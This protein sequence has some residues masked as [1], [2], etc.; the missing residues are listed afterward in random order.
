M[1]YGWKIVAVTCVTHFISVGFIFYSYGVFF[2]AL[3]EEFGGSRLSVSFGLALMNVATGIFAPFLGYLLDHR[4]IRNIMCIGTICMATGFLLASQI[5]ELWQFYFVLATFLGLGAAA[6]GGLPSSTLVAKW[7]VTQRGKALGISTMGISSSGLIMAPLATVLIAHIGWRQTFMAYSFASI[8]IVLPLVWFF[9]VSRPE[10]LGLHPDG[11][12]HDPDAEGA[13]EPMV[14]LAPGDQ[15]IDHAAHI[16]WSARGVM[17]QR[18][19]WIITLVVSMN[20]FSMG[21]MLTH[22]VPYVTDL[23]FS[24]QRAAFVLSA[25]AGAGVAGKLVFGWITDHVEIRIGFW[26]SMACQACGVLLVLNVESYPALLAAGAV[27]GFGM[28]GIVPLWGSLLGDVFGRDSFGRVMGLMSP[29]MLPIQT[30]GIPFAGYI[31]DRTQSY[32]IAFL[33]FLGAYACAAVI[34]LFLR[35]TN[36][37]Q[38]PQKLQTAADS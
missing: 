1:F 32:K 10:D 9:V 8:V 22:L 15:I 25:S 4:S 31:Y 30:T 17:R 7:F 3:T 34:L 36:S 28:G 23:G 13:V 12:S 33:V 11:A 24:L 5:R 38:N 18:N 2:K 14:P 29:C 6:I 21:A 16:E 27:F 26:I 19:F 37:A 20:F 35:P